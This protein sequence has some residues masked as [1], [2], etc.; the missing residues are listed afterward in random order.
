MGAMFIYSVVFML[1]VC[2]Q[3]NVD[4]AEYNYSIDE[5]YFHFAILIGGFCALFCSMF[6]GTEYSDGTIRNKIV[7]GHTR[8]N[9]YLAELILTFTATLLMIFVWLIGA[10]V[11][12]PALGVWEM[13]IPGFLVYLLT[14][15]MLSAAFAAIFT[16]ISM[17][18]ASKPATIVISILLFLGLYIFAI[19]VYN[20]LSQPEMVEG[21]QVTSNGMNISEP[22]PNPDYISGTKRK[23]YEFLLDF[24]PTGQ[25]LKI[26]L[27][28]IASPIRMLISSAFI[29]IVTT[30]IGIQFFK[31]KNIK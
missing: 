8:T 7:T 19:M 1:N 12:V 30:L 23:V 17:L 22:T 4:L 6:F 24:L 2:R 20:G 3:A 14:A 18:S 16:L 26:W 13:G 29:A 25:G 27:L 21:I 15:V 10:L 31:R 9:I 11:A 5:Y 28:E